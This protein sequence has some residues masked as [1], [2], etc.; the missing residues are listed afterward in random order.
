MAALALLAGGLTLFVAPRTN[1]IYYDEQ[2]YQSIGQNLADLRRAQMCND[3]TVEY[4]RLQCCRGEYNKQPYAYPHLLSLVYRAFGVSEAAAHCRERGGGD[5]LAVCAV[6]LLVT[7][8]FADPVAAA[9]GGSGGRADAATAALVGDRRRGADRLLAVLLAVL[10]AANF[11]RSRR[12]TAL[13]GAAVATA[14]AVQFR[15]ESVLIVPVV[16]LVLWQGARDEWRRPRCGG[17]AWRRCCSS[18]CTSATWSRSGTKGWGTTEAR[19]SLQYV[20]ATSA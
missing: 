12:T 10:A 16:A 4:G 2:I 7:L 9:F 18:P 6:Y 15:P 14:Y 1:R 20:A 11:C 13:L 8:L 17:S 5:G 19:L 3:G